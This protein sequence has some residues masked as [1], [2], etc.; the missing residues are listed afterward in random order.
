MMIKECINCKKW[1]STKSMEGYCGN[2]CKS[3]HAKRKIEDHSEHYMNVITSNNYEFAKFRSI[4]GTATTRGLLAMIYKAMSLKIVQSKLKVAVN[5]DIISELTEDCKVE[6]CHTNKQNAECSNKHLRDIHETHLITIIHNWVQLLTC[7]A[8]ER[9]GD[10]KLESLV[11][12][13]ISFNTHIRLASIDQTGEVL[14]LSSSDD[15]DIFLQTNLVIVC[16]EAYQRMLFTSSAD[17]VEMA[18]KGQCNEI[19]EIMSLIEN[20]TISVLRNYY[21][22]PHMVE[23]DNVVCERNDKPYISFLTI[24]K[25]RTINIR[26]CFADGT[27][28]YV[29]LMNETPADQAFMTLHTL[30]KYLIENFASRLP[31]EFWFAIRPQGTAVFQLLKD[32]TELRGL[33]QHQNKVFICEAVSQPIGNKTTARQ[34]LNT[35]IHDHQIHQSNNSIGNKPDADT[36]DF[37]VIEFRALDEYSLIYSGKSNL[38]LSEVIRRAAEQIKKYELFKDITLNSDS[39]E[40][41]ISE[42]ITKSINLKKDIVLKEYIKSLNLQDGNFARFLLETANISPSQSLKDKFQAGVV[43]SSVN[44]I[45]QVYMEHQVEE[46]FELLRPKTILGDIMKRSAPLVLSITFENKLNF[47]SAKHFLRTIP[48]SSALTGTSKDCSL[49]IRSLELDF[50]GLAE[51]YINTDNL[52]D[53]FPCDCQVSLFSSLK[54][55]VIHTRESWPLEYVK[56]VIYEREDSPE[57]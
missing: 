51:V 44:K 28:I 43:S 7:N 48:G 41:T 27:R 37:K 20:D 8:E 55:Q 34:P 21:T 1:Q 3:A 54:G 57:K 17:F 15:V 36:S 39:S 19:E 25:Y 35:G 6:C 13:T 29:A 23:L 46:Y 47:S 4:E 50:D 42:H 33:D 22:K 31:R 52:D 11:H 49:K 14:S 38:R 56:S 26:V 16:L 24:P 9:E 12:D 10:S 32:T 2:I 5:S 30:R 45:E 53:L 40:K 18:D